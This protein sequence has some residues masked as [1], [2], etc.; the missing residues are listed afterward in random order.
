MTTPT[1]H[2]PF[3]HHP[4]VEAQS[5]P[6]GSTPAVPSHQD[7]P[8]P[9]P[10]LPGVIPPPGGFSNTGW[11]PEA[12]KALAMAT[13]TA[14]GLYALLSLVSALGVAGTVNDA[15]AALES[16]D[17]SRSL[18][19]GVVE[20]LSVLIGIASFVLLALWMTKIRGNLAQKGVRA[21]GPPA[22]EW[23]GWFVPLANFVLPYLGMRAISRDKAS[24]GL[25]LG[26]WIPWCL[27]WILSFA[28]AAVSFAAIDFTTGEVSNVDALDASIPLAYLGAVAV[29]VSWAFLATI[30]RRVTARHL[31][32]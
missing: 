4:D 28:S 27:V 19:S 9:P 6:L 32:V 5:P 23:W 31:D 17:T 22:V 14:T 8:P 11:E 3:A 26:W 16:G 29:I 10:P 13:I 7:A 21:G 25:L 24:S 12:P 30:I 18:V 1:P 2:D 15:K 20:G